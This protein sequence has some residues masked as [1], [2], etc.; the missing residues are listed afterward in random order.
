MEMRKMLLSKCSTRLS[1]P[2]WP[3]HCCTCGG[4]PETSTALHRSPAI[5]AM[6][7]AQ[8]KRS[9]GESPRAEAG[10]R[11]TYDPCIA[12][13]ARAWAGVAGGTAVCADTRAA[14][15][16]SAAGVGCAK[17]VAPPSEKPN[18]TPNRS[19]SCTTSSESS[20]SSMKPQFPSAPSAEGPLP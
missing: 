6:V 13:V 3:M 14:C 9:R 5:V 15:R 19:A 17:T 2:A 16:A 8:A 12:I 7:S 20:P 18:A 10:H 1:K 11:P 4:C